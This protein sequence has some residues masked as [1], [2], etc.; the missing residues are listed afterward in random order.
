[1]RTLLLALGILAALTRVA[2][3]QPRN[4]NPDATGKYRDASDMVWK[5]RGD[6]V[7]LYSGIN[8]QG[9]AECVKSGATRVLSDF[10]YRSVKFYGKAKRFEITTSESGT[11]GQP[12]V[13][14][15]D[16]AWS[17]T[18]QPDRTWPWSEVP[19]GWLS[20]MIPKRAF[21]IRAF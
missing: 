1:M 13:L 14:T 5:M 19:P 8:F 15:Y 17:E 20:A 21:K 10:P 4:T 6:G 12:Q 18:E 3:A 11:D 9:E 2:S 16:S 7:C